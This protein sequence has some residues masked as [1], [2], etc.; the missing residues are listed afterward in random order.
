MQVSVASAEYIHDF[1]R[2][3]TAILLGIG[4]IIEHAVDKRCGVCCKVLILQGAPDVLPFRPSIVASTTIARNRM[5]ILYE[6]WADWRFVPLQL[7]HNRVKV[8]IVSHQSCSGL[9]SIL[10]TEP[11]LFLASY[12]ALIG[13]K[14]SLSTT[15]ARVLHTSVIPRNTFSVRISTRTPPAPSNS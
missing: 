11:V 12:G 3:T 13:K 6:R 9:W 8:D 10:I 7:W 14:S 1:A 5:P 4:P 15:I 2:L